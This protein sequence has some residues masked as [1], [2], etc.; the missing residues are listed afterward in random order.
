M[1]Q[2]VVEDPNFGQRL[3]F[4]RSTDED[5]GEVLHVEM[6]VDPG[7]GVPGHVHPAMEERFEVLAGRPSFLSGRKWLTAEPGEVVVVPAGVRHAYRN[8][9]DELAHVVCEA[10]PPSSLQGFLE[11]AAALGRDGKLTRRGLPASPGALLEAAMMAERH[12]EMCVLAFAPMPPARL[13]RIIFPRLAR[14]GERRG[15]TARPVETG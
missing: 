12:R 9:G 11:E 5:G 1:S 15:K 8:R 10:R 4:R 14:L 2:R 6:W 7:G 13:Q 3:S